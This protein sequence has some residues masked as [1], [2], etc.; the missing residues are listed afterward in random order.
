MVSKLLV[1][2][3]IGGMAHLAQVRV[4]ALEPLP[5][6]FVVLRILDERVCSIKHH[7]H[8]LPVGKALEQCAQLARRGL[9]ATLA[10]ERLVRVCAV[11]GDGLA[12]RRVLL[13][14]AEQPANGF[15]VVVVLLA[16]DD[17]L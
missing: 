2:T 16:L 3:A 11:P 4:H 17:D 8:A 9:Q 1:Q 6:P 5:Q 12:V 15:L 7:V 13:C 10:G 14:K